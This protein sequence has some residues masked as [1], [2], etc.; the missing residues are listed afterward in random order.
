MT[1]RMHHPP[2][3]S[4]IIPCYNY[5]KYI[6]KCIYSALNQT[7]S[8]IEVVVVDNGS[9]DDSLKKIKK[10]SQDKRLKVIEIDENIPPWDNSKSAVAIAINKSQGEYISILYADDWYHLDKIQKQLNLFYESSSSVGVIYCH[11]YC[12]FEK[13]KKMLQW[14][15]QSVRGYVFKDYLLNGDVVIP[16]SPLVKRFCYDIIGLNNPWTG[17]EY[18][19]LVM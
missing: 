15:H 17:S 14:K 3:V 12:Y 6:E 11:G 5:G 7:H 19:F 16:I 8:N 18:D 13:S 4:I 10:F 9:T 2:L 1:N